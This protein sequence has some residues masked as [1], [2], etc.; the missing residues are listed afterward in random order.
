MVSLPKMKSSN[1]KQIQML[2]LATV[3]GVEL[4]RVDWPGRWCRGGYF[5]LLCAHGTDE[6]LTSVHWEV[7]Q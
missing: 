2:R 4:A 6:N 3:I 1:F 5:T 7:C